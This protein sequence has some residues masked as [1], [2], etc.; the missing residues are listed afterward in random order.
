MKFEI[1]TLRFLSSILTALV[2]LVSFNLSAQI[3]QPA[4]YERSHKESDHSFLVISM[5]DKGIALIRDTDKFESNKKSW[6]AI[7]LDSA[8]NESWTTKFEIDQRMNILGHDFRDG[9]IYLIF[10][11]PENIGR[12]INLTEIILSERVVKQHKFKPDVTIQYT[13]FSVLKNKAVFGGYMMKE[14]TLLMYDLTSE[15]TK[16]IPGT[17]LMKEELM[18]V[19]N[20]S[21]D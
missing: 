16:V 18:D 13:H 19:R 5:G 11:E 3:T 9:N 17:F 1:I 7:L 6:E 4:L 10:E 2:C 15:S 8:L 20:N 14:P 21:N 12:Q